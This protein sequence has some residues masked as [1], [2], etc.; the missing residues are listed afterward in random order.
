MLYNLDLTS[1]TPILLHTCSAKPC[2]PCR[3][4]SL[5]MLPCR[6]SAQSFMAPFRSFR[7]PACLRMAASTRC[8]FPRSLNSAS[9]ISTG[10][11]KRRRRGLGVLSVSVGVTRQAYCIW[12]NL[13]SSK[14][15]PSLRDRGEGRAPQFELVTACAGGDWSGPT[16]IVATRTA[17]KRLELDITVSTL[18]CPVRPAHQRL[19]CHRPRHI[20]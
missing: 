18:R 1:A 15:Y 4:F 11:I 2:G 7:C 20:S 8:V 19:T 17:L 10:C 3:A 13:H 5:R 16:A 14:I 12:H 9:A 6:R